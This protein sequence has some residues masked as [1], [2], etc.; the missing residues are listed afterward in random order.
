VPGTLT[1]KVTLSYYLKSGGI[2]GIYKKDGSYKNEVVI[3]VLYVI[4]VEI[5]RNYKNKGTNYRDAERF[6]LKSMY[7]LHKGSRWY[8]PHLHAFSTDI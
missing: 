4:L 7:T 1:L 3:I 2:L 6:I 8:T 5:Q